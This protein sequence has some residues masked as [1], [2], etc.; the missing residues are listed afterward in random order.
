VP[1]IDDWIK[2]WDADRYALA[3]MPSGRYDELLARHVPMQVIA[4]DDRRVIVQKPVQAP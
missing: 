1:T 4:Q 3:L 2:R